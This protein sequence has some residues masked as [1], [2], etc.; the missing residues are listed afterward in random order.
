MGHLKQSILIPAYEGRGTTVKKGE[1]LCIIDVEGKQ[2]SDFICYRAADL[3]EYVSPVHMRSLLNSIRLR[4]G[5]YLY[6]NKRRPL[7]QLIADTV[8][9]HDF[10]FHAC[11]TLRYSVDFGIE[12]HPNCKDNLIAALNELGIARTEIPDP[13]NWFMNN[14][15]DEN[16]DYEI[17]EPLSGAGDYV[18]LR[19]VEDVIIA[20]T[21]CSQDQVPVNGMHVTPIC[22]EIYGTEED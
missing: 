13:I 10:F 15:M 6:S 4:E 3:G 1:E 12:N 20:A 14:Y 17:R 9:K 7:M 16:G 8:G 22:L 5:D 2:V 21:S 19:A 11:D 18:R